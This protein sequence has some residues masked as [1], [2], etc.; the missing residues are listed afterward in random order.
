VEQ[1]AVLQFRKSQYETDRPIGPLLAETGLLLFSGRNIAIGHA[2][3][4]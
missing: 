4:G 1:K 3:G 2:L